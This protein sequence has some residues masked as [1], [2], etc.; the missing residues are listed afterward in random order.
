[1]VPTYFLVGTHASRFAAAANVSLR[2][3][4]AHVALPSLRSITWG[5]T[6]KSPTIGCMQARLSTPEEIAARGGSEIPFL[7]LPERTSVFAERAARLRALAAGNAIEGYLR[8]IALVA[9]EQQKLLDHMPAIALPS[10]ATIARCNEHGMP[11]LDPRTHE[12]DPE[13]RN[14]LR[15]L[16]HGVAERTTGTLRET[17]ARLE[18]SPDPLYEAQAD[19]L[20]RG[21]RSGLDLATAPLVGAAL[22]AHFTHLVIALTPSAFPRTDVPTLC[23]CCGS[24]PA[25]SIARIG[26]Q[27]GGYRFLHC[28]LCNAEWHMVRIK[29]THCEGTKSISYQVVDDGTPIEKKAVKAEVCDECGTYLK[30]CDMQRDPMVDPVADDLATLPLDLLVAETGRQPSGTNFMLLYG[31]PTLE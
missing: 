4:M 11:P 5:H 1:M 29:C 8:F 27:E 20:L 22:Q 13:W 23:P 12:R 15:R 21:I 10:P 2:R 7:R 25:A 6:P 3:H 31:G 30:V 19:K 16:L 26:A 14:G 28:G 18:A 9:E 17:V 24:R